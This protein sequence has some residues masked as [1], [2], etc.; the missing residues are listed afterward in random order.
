VSETEGRAERQI[1]NALGIGRY[2]RHILLCVGPSCCSQVQ[3]LETWNYLK[4]RLKELEAAGILPP[5]C[6][7]RS[8]VSCLQICRGG[9]IL[10]IYPEGVWYRAVTREACE[11][12]LQEHVGRGQVVEDL[13]FAH[14]PLTPEV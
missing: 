4:S 3:G 8:K 5:T 1:A 14:N 11:R 12:I 6:I 13:A 9:P 2:Q 10:I 7:Y